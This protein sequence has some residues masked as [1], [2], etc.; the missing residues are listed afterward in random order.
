[1]LMLFIFT[2]ISLHL[3]EGSQ[4]IENPHIHFL[5]ANLY[6]ELLFSD[7]YS[8]VSVELLLLQVCDA[9]SDLKKSNTN[10]HP[11]WVDDLKELLHYD[12]AHLSLEY[13]SNE[14]NIHPVHISRAAPKYLSMSLGEYLRQQKLKKVFPLLFDTSMSFTQIARCSIFM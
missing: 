13:L 8:E 10:E 6:R 12:T 3:L 2:V 9:L 5:F 1:M 4:L 7:S 14:L 11:N